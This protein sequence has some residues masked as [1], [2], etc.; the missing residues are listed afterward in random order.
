MAILPISSS[1]QDASVAE[2]DF[3]EIGRRIAARRTY[4]RMTQEQLGN[5]AGVS[6]RTVALIEQGQNTGV[7]LATIHSI[8]HALGITLRDLGINDNHE[9]RP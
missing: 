7:R 8:A 9:E 5:A 1:I 3:E 2:L 4:R 6:Q